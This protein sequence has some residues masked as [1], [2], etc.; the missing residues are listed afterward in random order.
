MKKKELKLLAQQI[1]EWS[2]GEKK[3]G[4][5]KHYYKEKEA[6]V[7]EILSNHLDKK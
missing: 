7:L 1:I 3:E 6:E 4:L 5:N 2:E